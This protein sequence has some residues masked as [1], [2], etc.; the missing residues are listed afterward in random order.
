[1]ACSLMDFLCECSLQE[2][3]IKIAC[4]IFCLIAFRFQREFLQGDVE[5]LISLN[6]SRI[7]K[8]IY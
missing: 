5:N 8:I 4:V 2:I 3:L 7:M 1:M 6:A